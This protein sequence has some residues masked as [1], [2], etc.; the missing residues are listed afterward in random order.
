MCK[1]NKGDAHARR[2][3]RILPASI[4]MKDSF[5]ECAETYPE[6]K[7]GTL[8][9]SRLGIPH[10]QRGWEQCAQAAFTLVRPQA[11][12]GG[13]SGGHTSRISQKQVFMEHTSPRGNCAAGAPHI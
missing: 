6:T 10:M 5:Q 9:T 12:P 7:R 3:C 11:Q 1:R 13:T 8:Q 4:Q 2:A